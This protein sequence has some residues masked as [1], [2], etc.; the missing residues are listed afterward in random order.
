M[1]KKDWSRD[2][3]RH[4]QYSERLA[5]RYESLA[6]GRQSSETGW[7]F[8]RFAGGWCISGAGGV[9]GRIVLTK[10]KRG[11]WVRVR[12]VQE[13]GVQLWRFEDLPAQ[14][15]ESCEAHIAA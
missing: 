6:R 3:E 15:Q 11:R 2:R 12:L 5:E 14:K 9:E 7:T 1:T 10:T 13:C 8:R 4:R